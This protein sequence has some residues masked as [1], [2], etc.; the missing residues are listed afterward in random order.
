M[1][2]IYTRFL[3][4]SGYDWSVQKIKEQI[5]EPTNA[6]WLNVGGLLY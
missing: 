4:M 6:W 1:N 2:L 3:Q 5:M